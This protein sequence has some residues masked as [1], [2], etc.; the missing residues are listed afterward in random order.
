MRARWLGAPG[1]AAI[2]ALPLMWTSRPPAV[3]PQPPVPHTIAGTWSLLFGKFDFVKAAGSPGEYTDHV[4][5]QRLG[6][7]C[8]NANDRNGQIVLFQSKK[9]WR[10]YTGTWQWFYP[11]SCTPAGYGLVIVTLWRAKPY[12]FFTAYPPKGIRGSAD[13]FRIERVP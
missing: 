9:N 6:V 8:P 5:R 2:L 12:A 11:S 1:M 10:V 3:P 7:F 13:T 4:I